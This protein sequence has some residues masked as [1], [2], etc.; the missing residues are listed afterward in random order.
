M[1]RPT[2]PLRILVIRRDNIGDLLCTTPLIRALR[3]QLPEAYIVALV[4]RYNEAVLAGNPDI[5][6][7]FSYTKAKHRLQGE[8]I[9]GIY[10][11]RL[12]IIYDLRRLKFDCVLLPGGAQSSSL[13]FAKWISP[14]QILIRDD[15][16]RVAG[17]HEVEQCCH[18]LARMGLRFE[19]PPARVEVNQDRLGKLLAGLPENWRSSGGQVIGL[20]ISARKKSQRWP[21]ENFAALAR[22]LHEKHH[23]V[24]IL[25]WA[26]GRNNDPLHPGDDQKAE[27][28]VS[29]TRDLPIHPMPTTRLD[30][31]IEALSICDMVVCS[32]GGAMHLAAGLGKPVVAMFGQ[33]GADRWR[34]WGVPYRLLQKPSLE[35]SDIQ[36]E[37]VAD[38]A[39]NLTKLSEA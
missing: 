16:D 34:P 37:E 32:D 30:E 25:L 23:A 22:V 31:L 27:Q 2:T 4:T 11:R 20:H 28:V 6:A 15:A 19:T 3:A 35:A 26:P 38:A 18:L 29:L 5:D 9:A 13:R 33:S 10:L 14:K 36:V 1:S 7:L 39:L 17:P 21:A 12:K 24:F 8:S